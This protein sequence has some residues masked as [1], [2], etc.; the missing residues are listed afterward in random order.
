[1]KIGIDARFLTHPQKGG[2]KTYIENL[3]QALVRVDKGNEYIL[4][5]DRQPTPEAIVPRSSNF[6]YSVVA[7]TSPLL[8][9][10]WRE[11]V[12]L[13]YRAALD[14]LDLFHSPSLTAP[15]YLS[16]PLILTV[17]D[18]IWWFPV[19]LNLAR[20]GSPGRELM[21][22]YYRLIPELATRRAV[23][24]LTVSQTAKESIIHR[25]GVSSDHVVVTPEAGGDIFRRVE[26]PQMIDAVSKKYALHSSFILGIGSADPRKNMET[27]VRSYAQISPELREQ[28]HLAIVWT[29]PLLA[30]NVAEQVR[31]LGLTHYVHFL[32]DV[33]NEDLAL[34]YNAASL[35]VFPS[36][37][38]GFGLPPLE[39]MACGTPVISANNSSLPEITGDAAL[40]VDAEDANGMTAKM[41]Q[42][43]TDQAV[44]NALREKGIARAALFSWDRCAR[45]TVHAYQQA[46]TCAHPSRVPLANKNF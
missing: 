41:T 32:L 29:H 36:R 20:Q 44:H 38:E 6:R 42:I 31:N 9:M 40:L 13:T 17:H 2:F 46:V 5:V 37:Y 34:L 25:L 14:R 10:P 11:Q 21:R 30:G 24:V 27:L 7:G 19:K 23:I 45:Q 28:Y 26:D 39:A 16:C 22:W 35:F 1:M 33:P 15:L 3:I 8:G 18:T 12:G 4:Y 43:L